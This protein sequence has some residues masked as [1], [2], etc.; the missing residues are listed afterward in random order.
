MSGSDINFTNSIPEFYDTYLV[1]LIFEE[2][3]KDLASRVMARTP[4]SILETAAGSGVV[5][6]IISANLPDDA[7]LMVTD[8]NQDM[9]NHAQT[10][11]PAQDN[12][13]W[14]QAD[15]LDLPFE[16][17]MFD[18]VACQF[19]FMFMPDKVK[20]AAEAKRVLK[21]GGAFIFN[22]WDRLENNVFADLVTQAVGKLFPNDPPL[23]LDRVPHGYY[24]QDVIRDNLQNAGFKNISIHDKIATS[25]ALSALH[26]AMAYTHGTPL[27][28]ELIARDPDCLQNVALEAAKA[29]E[30]HCAD[31]EIAGQIRGFVI[32]AS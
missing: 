8:L 22:V 2:F 6:R 26:A 1:P 23:F 30:N 15:A 13:K 24:D 20:A 18:V 19:G 16:E 9:L 25:S 10:K 5:T 29:I 12:I 21:N 32:T 17:K 28:N 14:Q 3:A 11:Q 4:T 27:R 7:H 31:G